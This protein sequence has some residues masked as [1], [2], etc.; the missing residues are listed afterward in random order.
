[1]SHKWSDIRRRFSP[2]EEAEIDRLVAAEIAK[3]PGKEIRRAKQMTRERLA[4]VLELDREAVVRMER[5]ADIYLSTLR[6]YIEAQGGTL[7]LSARFAGGELL[8][9]RF[10]EDDPPP[11]R[12][13]ALSGSPDQSAVNA[14]ETKPDAAAP[15][16]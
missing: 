4:E 12:A 15:A 6:S 9:Q 8:M 10:G 16:A 5:W 3:L 2:E 14:P 11:A 1:M 7:E 13:Q